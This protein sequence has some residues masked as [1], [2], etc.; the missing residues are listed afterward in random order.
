ML[1]NKLK[2]LSLGNTYSHPLKK[3]V[4]PQIISTPEN[5]IKLSMGFWFDQTIHHGFLPPNLKYLSLGHVLNKPLDP[6]VFP[7]KS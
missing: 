5:V 4:L 2:F 3:G 1:P 7:K 6:G